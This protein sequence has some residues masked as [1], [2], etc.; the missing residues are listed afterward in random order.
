MK[1]NRFKRKIF[2]RMILKYLF[3]AIVMIG[4]LFLILLVRYV[5]YFVILICGLI[6]IYSAFSFFF[7]TSSIKSLTS[8]IKFFFSTK[9]NEKEF[10]D[11][12]NEIKKLNIERDSKYYYGE[13]VKIFLH[14]IEN[15]EMNEISFVNDDKIEKIKNEYLNSN[16]QWDGE[17]V[18]KVSATIS[19][20]LFEKFNYNINYI[21]SRTHELKGGYFFEDI[22]FSSIDILQEVDLKEIKMTTFNRIDDFRR[23]YPIDIKNIV[24]V[25][26]P[27]FDKSFAVFE[28]KE[29]EAIKIFTHEM[30][31]FLVQFKK[32]YGMKVEITIRNKVF[33]YFYGTNLFRI[34]K[35]KIN[36]IDVYTLYCIFKFMDEF[37]KIYKK[38]STDLSKK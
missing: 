34:N 10:K 14:K 28:A 21:I 2:M 5:A 22:I 6:F 31:N 20:S 11:I 18:D 19:G 9:Y 35:K 33:I 26:N 12:Y 17:K 29:G 27:K 30:T 4:G 3:T 38:N 7:E 13:L 1:K 23:A 8:S 37:T 15:I 25:E 16:F 36:K 24:N 32:Q